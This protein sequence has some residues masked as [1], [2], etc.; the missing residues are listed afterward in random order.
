MKIKE[1]SYI[2]D[3]CREKIYKKVN[4]SPG[5]NNPRTGMSGRGTIVDQLSCPSCG[6]YVSQK[7]KLEM[8][9][10]K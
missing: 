1:R 2:C 9:L 4:K 8:E 6:R 5:Q 10:K 7:T 3:W